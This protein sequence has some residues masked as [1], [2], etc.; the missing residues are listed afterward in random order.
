MVG[1]TQPDSLLRLLS[2]FA[3]GNRG[4]RTALSRLQGDTRAYFSDALESSGRLMVA[5]AETYRAHATVS[6]LMRLVWSLVPT[7]LLNAPS[8]DFRGLAMRVLIERFGEFPQR[9]EAARCLTMVFKRIRQYSRA[10]RLASS[11]DLDSIAHRDLLNE[12]RGRCAHCLYEFRSDNY[13]YGSEEDGVPAEP[14]Q[15]RLGEVSLSVTLRKPELDHIIPLILGGDS[16]S[17]WQILCKSCNLGK[18]DQVS[19]LTGLLGN[20]QNRMGHLFHLTTAKRYA[21][22]VDAIGNDE[23]MPSDGCYFR[24]FKKDSSGFS[25]PE[26]LMG[27]YC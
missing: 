7:K 24:I 17:N 2:V 9:E 1:L 25:N 22:L 14:E 12:Q 6:T 26:N 11:L 3:E 10:G 19:Y 4:E 5:G 21:V 18:S 20:S 16:S 27:V 23:M 8:P 13:F 15:P